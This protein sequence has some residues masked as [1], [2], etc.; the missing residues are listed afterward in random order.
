MATTNKMPRM[1]RPSRSLLVT[2]FLLF[3]MLETL[4]ALVLFQRADDHEYFLSVANFG[5]A[6]VLESGVDQYD[7]KARIAASVFYGL[8]SPARWLG[9]SEIGHL[10]W[11]RLIMLIG[12]LCA[13]EATRRLLQPAPTDFDVT[14]AR[15]RFLMLCLLYPG[16]LAWTASLLRD[17]PAC[18]FLFIALLAWSS[19]QRILAM[20]FLGLSTALRPEFAAVVVLLT[21]SSML[22]M[23]LRLQRYRITVLLGAL[24]LVS[25]VA[26]EPRQAASEFAQYAFASEGAAYPVVAHW[27]DIAGY[28]MVSVQSLIDPMSLAAPAAVSPFVLAETLFFV[29]LIATGLSRLRHSQLRAAGLI[30]GLLVA[31]WLF[32]YFETYVS[33][34]SRHRLSLVIM[35]LALITLTRWTMP[36]RRCSPMTIAAS[37][38]STQIAQS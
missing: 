34:F 27:L 33:G 30:F 2:L 28:A 25:V 31:L 7:L 6:A 5:T 13:F 9:G 38:T 21:A 11:L 29:W 19:R 22:F 37:T 4:C 23:R 8:M 12:M 32:A 3:G 20:I 15:S 1:L 26:F 17:G 14:R 35:M 24:A 16:Q 36:R 10:L 18:A